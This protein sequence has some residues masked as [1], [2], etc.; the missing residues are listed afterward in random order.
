[1]KEKIGFKKVL[2]IINKTGDRC[3]IV[4][5][6]SDEAYAIMSLKEY[7]RIMLGKAQVTELTEDELLDK[8]NRDI[9]VWKSQQEEEEN[10]NSWDREMPSKKPDYAIET[11]EIG[12][13]LANNSEN[14]PEWAEWEEDEDEDEF[15]EEPYYFEKT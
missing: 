15:E 11:P 13:N 4:S 5:E 7:E 1:M 12:D 10:N 8:I 3:I 14:Y 9:A 2:D 6:T